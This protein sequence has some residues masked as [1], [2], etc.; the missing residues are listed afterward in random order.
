MK[1]MKNYDR[2]VLYSMQ[3]AVIRGNEN[4]LGFFRSIGRML[5]RLFNRSG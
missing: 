3:P 5:M 2:F 4:R 1:T